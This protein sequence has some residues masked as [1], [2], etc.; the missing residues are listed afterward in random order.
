MSSTSPSPLERRMIMKLHKSSPS[1]FSL[2]TCLPPLLLPSL[3][4]HSKPTCHLCHLPDSHSPPQPTFFAIMTIAHHL[5]MSRTQIWLKRICSHRF[6]LL[7]RS[8]RS[9]DPACPSFD[10]QLQSLPLPCPPP[11]FL[12]PLSPLPPSL[13]L[14]PCLLL[15]SPYLS[16][17]LPPFLPV[18]RPFYLM[19]PL[20]FPPFPFLS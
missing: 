8:V 12:F 3:P 19:P 6:F 7:R 16:H 17:S 18:P 13:L 1:R 4:P 5:P 15:L 20:S 10:H 9:N 14:L 11:L 2:S